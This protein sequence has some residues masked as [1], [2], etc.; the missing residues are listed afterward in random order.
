MG[1]G[2]TKIPDGSVQIGNW[3]SNKIEGLAIT[4]DATGKEDILIMET[5]NIKYHFTSKEDIENRRKSEE[6]KKLIDFYK[7]I[8]LY[9][10]DK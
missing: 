1:L 6:Y 5:G 7:E 10:K 3:K 4:Y 8:E 2:I 9:N